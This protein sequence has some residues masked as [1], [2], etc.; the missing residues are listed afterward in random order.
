MDW[1][2]NIWA[3]GCQVMELKVG[4]S[5]VVLNSEMSWPRLFFGDI[6]NQ[7]QCAA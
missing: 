5:R 1:N 7:P 2:Q 4:S 6:S 3:V